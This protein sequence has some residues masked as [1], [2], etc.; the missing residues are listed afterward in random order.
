MPA[1]SFVD[2]WTVQ[3]DQFIVVVQHPALI[4]QTEKAIEGG[5]G[6]VEKQIA[7]QVE[8]RV[9]DAEKTVKGAIDGIE[10][11]LSPDE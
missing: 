6:G 1:S 11:F 9:D 4:E 3:F 2:N 8:K 7:K 10:K 5:I